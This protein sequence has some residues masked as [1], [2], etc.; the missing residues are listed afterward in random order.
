ML[1]ERNRTKILIVEDDQFLSNIYATIFTKKNFQVLTAGT[2]EEGW[3]LAEKEKPNVVL[4]DILL[5][6]SMNGLSVLKKMRENEITLNIP[7]IILSNC[8]DDSTISEGLKLGANGYFI[9]TQANP[10]DVYRN[11]MTF[12][13]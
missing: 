13:S 12:I 1:E 9:K 11:V 7:V 10:D 3:T 2:G 6:G 4:L 8:D 5:P